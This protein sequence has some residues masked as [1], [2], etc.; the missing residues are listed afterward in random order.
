M[1][2]TLK[3]LQVIS[4]SASGVTLKELAAKLGL[5]LIDLKRSLGT[6]QSSYVNIFYHFSF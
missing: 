6:F 4:I 2:V 3:W 1:Q 5:K